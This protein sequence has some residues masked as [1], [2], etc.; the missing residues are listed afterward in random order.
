MIER[1]AEFDN[2]IGQS[3]LLVRALETKLPDV[4]KTI[5]QKVK[6]Q[7]KDD[8]MKWKKELLIN[9]VNEPT[10]TN[11]TALSLASKHNYP[12]CI[13]LILECGGDLYY[14]QMERKD[15]EIARDVDGNIMLNNFNEENKKKVETQK[16]VVPLSPE[17]YNNFLDDQIRIDKND[18]EKDYQKFDFM[19]IN[20]EQKYG[21]DLK[22]PLR[23][24]Q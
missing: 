8:K 4:A 13:K 22:S 21:Y 1:D 3:T 16:K 11:Q 7:L 19:Y 23:A 14:E 10:K 20:F 6:R 18:S 15:Q 5:L 24:L 17:D 12:A 9:Y 2:K